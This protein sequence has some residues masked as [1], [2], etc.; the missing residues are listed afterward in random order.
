[1]K[2]T[3]LP[4]RDWFFAL[5]FFTQSKNSISS[6]EV[7]SHLG[8]TQKNAWA[9]TKKLQALTKETS[10]DKFTGIVEIDVTYI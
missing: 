7:A 4:M 9:L 5:Y 3:K 10:R 8:I 1:M 2:D 6:L